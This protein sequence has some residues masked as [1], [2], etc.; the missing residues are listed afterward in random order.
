MTSAIRAHHLSIGLTAGL[1]IQALAGSA[2]A[3]TYDIHV[4][5]NVD[6]GVVT[7]GLIG[8]SVF[9]VDPATGS[10]SKISGDAVRAGAGSARALVTISCTATAPTDCTRNVNVR[11]GVAGAPTKRNGR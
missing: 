4:T 8:D 3:Q 2:H 10:V 11:L 7:S 1:A 9:R 6:L 5:T